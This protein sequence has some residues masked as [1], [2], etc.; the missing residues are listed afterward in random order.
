MNFRS[1]ELIALYPAAL[2]RWKQKAMAG[3]TTVSF[4]ET[5]K[6]TMFEL[7]QCVRRAERISI[8]VGAGIST[9][10]GIPVGKNTNKRVPSVLT[11]SAS[12]LSL[13]GCIVPA[14][15]TYCI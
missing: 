6:C 9:D 14:A 1:P 3:L 5:D 10:A 7:V 8:I 11:G 12:G 4:D 13:K 2:P 15:R